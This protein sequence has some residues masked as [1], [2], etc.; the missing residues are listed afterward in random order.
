L[1]PA[2]TADGAAAVRPA[3]IA[4]HGV[5]TLAEALVMAFGPAGTATAEGTMPEWST[6]P[7]AASR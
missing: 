6:L 2:S 3:D 1:V 5:R 7:A 4:V